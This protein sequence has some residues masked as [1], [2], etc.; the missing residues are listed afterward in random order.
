M[1]QTSLRRQRIELEESLKLGMLKRAQRIIEMQSSGDYYL[2]GYTDLLDRFRG[3]SA[4]AYPVAGRADRSFG[5]NYPFWTNESQLAMLRAAS[6]SLVTMNG[7]AH[8]FLNGM[9]S[10]V[11]GS[12]FHYTANLIEKSGGG[13]SLVAAVQKV[14]D[15]FIEENAWA[16][17]EQEL[18]YR[19]REDGEA[20]LRLFPQRDGMLAVR[21]VEPEQVCQPNDTTFEEWSYGIQTDP[22][23]VCSIKSYAI[24]YTASGGSDSHSERQFDRVSP[25]EIVH[26]KVNVKRSIK[27]GLTDFCFDT[28]ESIQQAGKLRRNLGEGASVQAAIA[29]IRQHDTATASQVETFVQSAIEYSQMTMTGKRN[30][31][32]KME[33]GS[34]L[35]IPKGM[36]YITPPGSANSSAHI[37]IMSALLRAAAVRHNAPEWLTSADASNSNY[38]SSLTAESPFLRNCTRMQALY[39][40]QFL[41]VIRSSVINAVKAGLLPDDTLSKVDIQCVP[42]SLETRDKSEE[43]N[44]NQTYVSMGIKSR[45]TVA[46]EIG[47]DWKRELLNMN[48][49]ADQNPGMDG[50]P[51][52]RT[53]PE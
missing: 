3:D 49:Y 42:P 41:R 2:Q 18:F 43:A 11:I 12:G 15:A 45:Q 47:L 17:L 34:F 37:E 5:S 23:D 36:N 28:L 27:R 24:H 8:G 21:T 52:D 10:Y 38:A 9:T 29:A 4:A 1:K 50:E 20:F 30:D 35:D 40:R 25:D 53:P 32:Q 48:E 46:Q 7:C 16:E 22:D 39:K 6:R 51:L 14:I 26:I 19:S 44:S 33:P 31:Y 13:E